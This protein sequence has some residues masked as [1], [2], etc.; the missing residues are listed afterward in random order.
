MSGTSCQSPERRN[1]ERLESLAVNHE[2]RKKILLE[3]K[4]VDKLELQYG[5]TLISLMNVELRMNR[6]AARLESAKQD[7]ASLHSLSW[8]SSRSLQICPQ[9]RK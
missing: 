3:K 9:T 2:K 6:E 7:Q 8:K 4:L 5:R 1:R